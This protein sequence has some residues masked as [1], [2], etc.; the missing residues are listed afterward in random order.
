MHHVLFCALFALVTMA[1]AAPP[2][3]ATGIAGYHL[4]LRDHTFA[5]ATLK[6]PANTKFK[7]FVTNHNAMPAEFESTD[8]SRE[9]IV[10]PNTTITVFIGPLDK[11]KYTFYDDFHRATTGVLIAE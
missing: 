7:L 5:P 9:K 3:S 8:L 11:G 6:V 2:A 10:M 1:S 4:V